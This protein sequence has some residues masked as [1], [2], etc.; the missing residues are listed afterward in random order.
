VDGGLVLRASGRT[1]PDELRN[2]LKS[3]DDTDVSCE[4]LRAEIDKKYGY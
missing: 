1:S 4:D 2:R 3:S